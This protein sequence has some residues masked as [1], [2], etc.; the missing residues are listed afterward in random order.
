[1]TVKNYK[2]TSPFKMQKINRLRR[3]S[4][5]GEENFRVARLGKN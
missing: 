3:L 4:G 1:M 5:K 2:L